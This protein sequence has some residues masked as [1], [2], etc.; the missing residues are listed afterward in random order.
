MDDIIARRKL[1]GS[2]T[3]KRKRPVEDEGE[4]ADSEEDE[5]DED[6]DPEAIY[7]IGLALPYAIKHWLS[8]ASKATTEIAGALSLENDF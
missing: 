8:H 7:L 4:E 5:D 2:S 1:R 3:G 6:E